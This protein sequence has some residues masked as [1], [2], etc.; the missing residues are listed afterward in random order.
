MKLL[1][2]RVFI[3]DFERLQEDER[4]R[5]RGGLEKI[6]QNPFRGKR[7]QGAL[8]G[9]ISLR[10]GPFRII[11]TIDSEGFIWAETVRSRKEVYRK[12]SQRP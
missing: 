4:N 5:I 6:L 3:R 8:K 11:Y 12:R 7:L 2:T 1:L 9:E 10:V